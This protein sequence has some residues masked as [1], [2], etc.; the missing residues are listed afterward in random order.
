MLSQLD[1]QF[2]NLTNAAHLCEAQRNAEANLKLLQYLHDLDA[3][4]ARIDWRVEAAL[5]HL[6]W[7]Y[8]ITMLEWIS[9][10]LFAKHH[11]IVREW[12][13]SNTCDWLLQHGE[14]R[15]WE[16]CS[17]SAVMWVRGSRKSTCSNTGR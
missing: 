6:E 3:P 4:L 1:D 2:S 12:R 17:S 15:K 11:N 7:N 10:I 9:P 16:E 8:H 13:L 14:F 5:A